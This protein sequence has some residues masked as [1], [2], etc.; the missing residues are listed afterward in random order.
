[1]MEKTN[2]DINEVNRLFMQIGLISSNGN[3]YKERYHKHGQLFDYLVIV[4]AALKKMSTKRTIVLLDCGCGRSYLSFFLNYALQKE[5][6]KNLYFVGVDIKKELIEKCRATASELNFTNMEFTVNKIKDFQIEK[7][8]DI[9]FS[10]H[11][12]DIATDQTILEGVLH[13]TQYIFS[14][15]CCQHTTRTQMKNNPLRN[16]TRFSPYKERITDMVSDSLRALLL[17]IIGYKVSIFEFTPT[18]NIPKNIMLRAERIERSQV[19]IEKAV[20]EYANLSGMFH[21]TPVLEEYLQQLLSCNSN[22]TTLLSK[23]CSKCVF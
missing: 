21:I 5:G 20:A 3:Y 22:I 8:V 13:N 10:L 15:S 2:F 17:E 1:M 4:R 18:A 12:C 9:V 19:K 16:V 7:K 6:Y 23:E 11:A 14:V